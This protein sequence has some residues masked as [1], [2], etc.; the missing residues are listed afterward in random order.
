MVFVEPKP[1]IEYAT[2]SNSKEKIKIFFEDCTFTPESRTFCG[3]LNFDERISSEVDKII[4]EMKFNEG[5]TG[6]ETSRE[7]IFVS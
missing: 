4:Y 2:F 6:N 3:T 5:Y 1:F 7:T